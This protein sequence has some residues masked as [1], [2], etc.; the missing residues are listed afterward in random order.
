MSTPIV[1]SDRYLAAAQELRDV[2]AQEKILAERKAAAKK[3]LAE[4][5]TDVGQSAVDEYGTPLATMRPGQARFDAELAIRNLPD[6]ALQMIVRNVPD[7]KL[8]REVLPPALY[9]QCVVRSA[10]SIV[11]AQ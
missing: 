11:A 7:A 4:V 5:L 2:M 9:E 1:L 10:P 6:A 3:I 8:A